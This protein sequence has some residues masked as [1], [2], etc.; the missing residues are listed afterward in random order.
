MALLAGVYSQQANAANNK[1]HI[2]AFSTARTAAADTLL[3]IWNGTA[4]TARKFVVVHIDPDRRA[5]G[6]ACN[7]LRRTAPGAVENSLSR[8]TPGRRRRI[9][10]VHDLDQD[11]NRLRCVPASQDLNVKASLRPPARVAASALL[12]SHVKFL[13]CEENC[14]R[15][16][17]SPKSAP[18][19][20]LKPQICQVKAR[21]APSPA[22]AATIASPARYT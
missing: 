13:F 7:N 4:N 5:V 12:P 10:V 18:D 9:L 8:S 19:S 15:G 3:E 11:G 2:L 22:R 16:N 1:P 21:I 14:G 17:G 6:I 20:R